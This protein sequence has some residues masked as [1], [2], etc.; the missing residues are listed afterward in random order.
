MTQAPAGWHPDP[1]LPG[2]PGALRYWD[3]YRWTGHTAF[4]PLPAAYAPRPPPT[5][6][7]GV[8]LAGWGQRAAAYLVD[9]AIQLVL[10]LV[11]AI[12]LVLVNLDR[13]REFGDRFDAWSQQSEPDGLP[14]GTF[15]LLL[16]LFVELGA[17]SLLVGAV[18]TIA[19]WRWKQATPGKLLLGLRIRR[20]DSPDLPWSAIWLRYGFFLALG[21]VGLVPFVGYA[22]GLVQLL[23]YLW[24]L[25]DDQRQALHD[26]VAGT[27]VVTLRQA[28]Q[29]AA[30]AAAAT[31]AG[32][33]PRW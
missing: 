28:P 15:R 22:T 6:P 23:D 21:V 17:A 1:W 25:W 5:T 24:P 12:P 26:K 33:P 32:L 8:L 7:D 11:A 16:P 31:A 30:E 18:Y 20:R 27:N 10:N 4:R 9:G 13:I 3:G 29:P 14:S 2:Q 19:F